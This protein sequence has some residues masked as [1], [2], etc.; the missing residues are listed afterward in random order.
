ME[1][2]Y[3]GNRA[4]GAIGRIAS[5][6]FSNKLNIEIAISESYWITVAI[7]YDGAGAMTRF[8]IESVLDVPEDVIAAQLEEVARELG[9]IYFTN[10]KSI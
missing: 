5:R 9:R 4:M 2:T 6:V 7:G 8:P 1:L 3:Y 10:K